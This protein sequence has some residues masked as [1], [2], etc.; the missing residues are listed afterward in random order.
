AGRRYG[1]AGGGCP[2]PHP[3]RVHR[4]PCQD[5]LRGLG[6]RRGRAGVRPVA[7]ADGGESGAAGGGARARRRTGVRRADEPPHGPGAGGPAPA[8][9]H[10]RRP[11]PTPRTPRTRVGRPAVA[12]PAP[13]RR[14]DGRG[15]GPPPRADGPRTPAG[16]LVGALGAP[17][18]P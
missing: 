8:P 4:R 7:G 3:V 1:T 17:V 5:V 18:R 14:G 9:P 10:R 11:P 12:G 15:G 13:R 2:E 16:D 6:D